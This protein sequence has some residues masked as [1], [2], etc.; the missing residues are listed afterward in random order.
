MKVTVKRIGDDELFRRA[1][2]MTL[3]PGQTS[4]VSFDKMLQCEHSPVRVRTY[5]IEMHDIPTFVSV[6]LVRHKTGVEHFVQSNR[7]DRGG[8]GDDKVT[9]NTPVNHGMF[10]NAATLMG[11]SRKRLCFNSHKKTVAVWNM[12]RKSLRDVDPDVVNH[13]VPECVVRGYCP[14]LRP[15]A[16]GP[17]KVIAAYKDSVPC[18][19]RNRLTT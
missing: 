11:I 2:E 16:P 14:E 1:C 4:K 18:R 19:L 17:Q 5:W 13:L 12:V 6:H 15:C 7:D 8:A 10:L 9:R 3:R